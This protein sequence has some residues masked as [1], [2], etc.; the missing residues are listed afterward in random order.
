[1]FINQTRLLRH[2]PPQL[3]YGIAVTDVDGD[4]Q[5]EAVV[6]GFG[7]PNLALKWNGKSFVDIADETL[8]DPGRSAIGVAAADI[9]DDGREEI[10]FLNSDT[11][12]GLKSLADR[13]FVFGDDGWR[14]L[15]AIPANRAA[16]NLTAGRSVAAVDRDGDGRYG[17]FV[18]NYGGPMRLYELNDDGVIVDVAAEAGLDLITGGRSLLALPLVT[19]RMD[20]FAGNEGGPNFLFLNRGQGQYQERGRQSGLSDPNQHARGVSALDFDGDG[21]FDLVLGNWEGE[22]RLYRH[23]PDHAFRNEAPPQMA[24]P[25]R[26][27]TVIAADF[28]NDGYEEIFFNNIGEPNR[29]FGRRGGRWTKLNI[30]EAAEPEGLGTG[31]ATGDFDGDGRLELIIAHGESDL[32][33]LSLY[34]TQGNGN[35]YLRVL[36]LTRQ[37]APA[38]GAVVKLVAEGRTQMRAIDAGSGYLCQMEPLAHF[39]LGQTPRIERVEIRWLDGAAVT[40]QNPA[41]NQLLRIPHPKSLTANGT[42]SH[43]T[44][45]TNS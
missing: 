17:F 7:Y 20:I 31:A 1:M 12:G 40:I 38:R 22:H 11:F 37:G 44:F 2:N 28:D 27:R 4:G 35:F 43:E 3:N 30:G 45:R 32:Q 5:F 26:V 34:H 13:L 39:G 6:A 19:V 18:A 29:L 9:D 36:P 21:R 24:E 23:L 25:S 10:Y 42:N 14:D 8:A 41:P 33:P 16:L 15:F